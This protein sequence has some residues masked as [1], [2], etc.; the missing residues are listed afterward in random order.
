MNEVRIRVNV[1][2]FEK[3]KGRLLKQSIVSEYSVT[4]KREILIGDQARTHAHYIIDKKIGNDVNFDLLRDY[5][6]ENFITKDEVMMRN[7]PCLQSI[8]RWALLQNGSDNCKEVFAG[9]DF[10]TWRG[11]LTRMALTLFDIR[12]P[13]FD[14]SHPSYDP[15]HPINKRQPDAWTVN[16]LKIGRVIL[17][18]EQKKEFATDKDPGTY[19]GYK[20]EQYITSKTPGGPDIVNKLL[21]IRPMF[22]M[23]FRRDLDLNGKNTL[24]LFCGAEIDALR[25]DT[26]IELK[27]T[28]EQVDGPK[29]DTYIFN[30]KMRSIKNTMQSEIVGVEN[31]VFGIKKR[32]PKDE[33]GQEKNSYIVN[34]VFETTIDDYKDEWDI[35]EETEHCY[36]FLHKILFEVKE[37]LAYKEACKISFDPDSKAVLIKKI[38]KE[39]ASSSVTDDFLKRFDRK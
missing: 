8:C 34:Q 33:S 7:E 17:L 11:T 36:A 19:S 4:A 25:G 15:D 10:V 38:S 31:I 26:P 20:F 32:L 29:P 12:F 5:S 37:F 22:E 23:M 30:Q 1:D 3:K 13:K 28:K 21:D 2:D 24:K 39:E 35:R 27:T 18:S 14:P 16:A 9:A 6:E